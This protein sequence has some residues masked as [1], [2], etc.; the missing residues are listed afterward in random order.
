MSL[1]QPVHTGEQFSGHRRKT[2][3]L[4]VVSARFIHDQQ[5]GD[6]ELLVDI[7]PTTASMQD[8]H[9]VPPFGSLV[10]IV[11]REKGQQGAWHGDSFPLRASSEEQ[12]LAVQTGT[13]RHL[14]AH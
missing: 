9:N 3:D 1:L 7:D 13:R 2:A 8:L 10:C 14:W 5:T 11:T 6:E 12:Q 4:L